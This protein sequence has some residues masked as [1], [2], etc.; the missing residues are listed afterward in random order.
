[1][2]GVVS[3]WAEGSEYGFVTGANGEEYL[4]HTDDL[5]RSH[6]PSNGRLGLE[7]MFDAI[8]LTGSRRANA[9]N[10]VILNGPVNGLDP[11]RG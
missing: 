8:T 6:R 11:V 2:K 5:P 1:M 9:M 7:V 4:L 3:H 10:V